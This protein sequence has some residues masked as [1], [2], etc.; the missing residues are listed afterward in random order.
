VAILSGTPVK[1]TELRFPAG[2]VQIHRTRLAFIHLDHLLHFAKSDRDGKVDGY[3]AAYL[4]DELALLFLRNGEVVTSVAFSEK[5][6]DVRP[7][8]ATCKDMKD[9]MERGDLTFCEA[10][11]EL[12]V[13]LYHSALGPTRPK[14]VN[15]RDPRALFVALQQEHFNGVLELIVNGAVSYLRFDDGKF[16]RG[17]F[18]E[19]PEHEAVP[20]YLERIFAPGPAGPAV[21]AASEFEPGSAIDEQAPPAMVSACREVFW[22]IAEVAEREVPGEALNRA[23]KLKDLLAPTHPGLCVVAT[24]RNTEPE[25]RLLTP[26]G[27]TREL[28]DWAAQLLHQLEV[29]A[30]GVA[31]QVLQEA[32]REHRFVLQRAGFFTRLPWPVKW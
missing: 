22:R 15:P 24:P 25:P 32:T 18:A 27:L 2:R 30:P 16:Q 20:A 8:A 7:I 13:W 1:L 11:L 26:E 31:P 28:S 6:R 29:I 23:H 17:Y 5:G 4:P 10:P 12:L 9:E 14:S 3:I 21:V 19:K